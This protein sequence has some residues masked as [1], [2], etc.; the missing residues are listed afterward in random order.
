MSTRSLV[1]PPPAT[2]HQRARK[3]IT[4]LS[5]PHRL[6]TPARPDR[7]TRKGTHQCINECSVK[8]LP[9]QKLNGPQIGLRIH[10]LAGLQPENRRA[11]VFSENTRRVLRPATR[12]MLVIEFD[13]A[14]HVL[15]R[16]QG[17]ERVWEIVGRQR[18]LAVNGAVEQG[19]YDGLS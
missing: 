9:M 6:L 15:A 13:H 8:H 16:N 18:D 1:S 5:Q 14:Q 17:D 11:G 10:T 12:G 3:R 2:C 4:V 19:R 7:S